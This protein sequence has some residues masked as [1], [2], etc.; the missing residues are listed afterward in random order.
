MVKEEPIDLSDE[1]LTEFAAGHELPVI[2]E[3]WKT[4]R[5]GL[6][7][8]RT[9]IRALP[10]AGQ[11]RRDEWGR[12]IRSCL[13]WKLNPTSV[14]FCGATGSGK[15]T[16][17]NALLGD[18]VVPTHGFQ[19]CT[20]VPVTL[21]YHPDDDIKAE[22]FFM[23][24]EEFENNL[25]AILGDLYNENGTFDPSSSA[26][27]TA[28]AWAEVKAIYP[29][30]IDRD[31]R[32]LM[33][34]TA[35]DLLASDEYILTLLARK[36]DTHRLKDLN[37]FAKKVHRYLE[38]PDTSDPRNS[39]QE[40]R[41][42]LWPLVK[43]VDVYIKAP[44]LSTGLSL[45]DLP[46]GGDSN[47]T[48]TR[49]AEKYIN[50]CDHL[51]ISSTAVR[52][53]DDA[54]SRDLMSKAF[55]QRLRFR[56]FTQDFFACVVTK[57]DDISCAEI[58]RS[59]NLLEDPDFSMISRGYDT[60]LRDLESARKEGQV[61]REHVSRLRK[62]QSGL[63]HGKKRRLNDGSSIGVG[64]VE[65]ASPNMEMSDDE[66]KKSLYHYRELV[67]EA[68]V[69]IDCLEELV[70]SIGQEQTT[71]CARKRNAR[72]KEM[73]N[74][75]F[76]DELQEIRDELN[77]QTSNNRGDY[78]DHAR[79]DL[80]VFPIS[81]RDYC[82]IKEDTGVP[83]L[84]DFLQLKARPNYDASLKNLRHLISALMLSM[85]H[86]LDNSSQT[87]DEHDNLRI[88]MTKRWDS[89]YRLRTV[90]SELPESEVSFEE[91]L[92]PRLKTVLYI[93]AEHRTT[94]WQSELSK[95]LLGSMTR[96]AS[97]AARE[98]P[99]ALID[100]LRPLRWQTLNAILRRNGEYRQH[101]LNAALSTPF[102]T[103]MLNSWESTWKNRM[104]QQLKQDG[105]D[106][107]NIVLRDVELCVAPDDMQPILSATQR[108]IQFA[109][110]SAQD[111]LK[112]ILEEIGQLIQSSQ[113]A[114]SQDIV[115]YI[116]KVME[117]AY[118]AAQQETGRGSLARRR[119]VLHTFVSKLS[120]KLY[121]GLSETLL[122]GLK[123]TISDIEK[124]LN[125][126]FEQLAE[127]IENIVTAAWLLPRDNADERAAEVRVHE[128]LTSLKEFASNLPI[129][130]ITSS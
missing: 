74:Q 125:E 82:K 90:K 56:R 106:T 130:E 92:A 78:D 7:D 107:I 60:A 16:C 116:E 25:N 76:L 110:E 67:E 81:A 34:L 22:I 62:M 119:D 93:I 112:K 1:L 21:S 129:T 77:D 52:S 65:P 9:L 40:S 84:V 54:V 36:K 101:N 30:V 44:I 33:P 83:A 118:E 24:F 73:L 6:K 32:D 57:C 117:P 103:K 68:Q 47:K 19:A 86:Y 59:M 63:Q 46:G 126:R 27:E 123:K 111:G 41:R 2:L 70:Q 26:Q 11:S 109:R 127:E 128:I 18:V 13:N 104:F 124:L 120:D 42:A 115:P 87:V 51:L 85:A 38:P 31:P 88:T 97:A 5:E 91:L 100:V 61:A 53:A 3:G 28:L 58:I 39:T 121:E 79:R 20:S 122:D 43:K 71:L 64:S 15:S 45:I 98:A 94:D 14:A 10:N 48:R 99:Q 55:R 102:I 108:Q 12:A 8:L 113:V 114:L 35:K 96:A 95:R 49:M 72:I 50:K 17:L 105:I 23:S 37:D 89:A 75:V 29:H 4:H 80:A 66:I 69:K